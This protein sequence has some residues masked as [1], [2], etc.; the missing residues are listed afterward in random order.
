[1][2]RRSHPTLRDVAERS[3]VSKS[4]VSRVINDD[5]YVGLEAR[6]AVTQAMAELGY[7]RNEVARSLRL[8]STGTVG[9]IVA[10]LRNEV[11][12]AIAQGVGRVLTAGER[13]LLVGNSDGDPEA[14]LRVLHEF[15]RRGVDGLIIS[16]VNDRTKLARDELRKVQVPTVLLDR[17]TQGSQADR[18]LTDHRRGLVAAV[19]DVAGQGHERIGLVGPPETIRPGRE[20]KAAFTEAGG[21]EQFVRSG[22]LTEEF[23]HEAS[24]ELLSRDPAPTAL[25]VAGTQVLAG[26]L[27][28]LAER[29]LSPPRDLSLVAYDDSA[30]ARFHTPPI[31]ALVRDTESIG[32][33]AAQLVTERI[34]TGRTQSKKSVVPT[35]YEPRGTVGPP[36]RG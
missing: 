11:F 8:R 20:T 18:V 10:S 14:E 19:A 33:L 25:V 28:T 2:T 21:H 17:D 15:L 30:A 24:R 29:G 35:R 13:T 12:A 1:M 4:T 7:R 22:P 16:L 23:G 5:P 27:S 6:R 34:E 36:P 31:S 26:V 9:L 32:E 3:G